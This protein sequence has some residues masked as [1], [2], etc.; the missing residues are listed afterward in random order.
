[1]KSQHQGGKG[2]QN[3]APR[4]DNKPRQDAPANQEHR[5]KPG[6]NYSADRTNTKSLGAM[7]EKERMEYY[8]KKYGFEPK[9]KAP[10]AAPQKVQ[11]KANAAEPVKEETKQEKP[12]K[13]GFFR[14]LF[15]KK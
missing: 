2:S 10:E 15:G 1:Q 4:R 9:A 6:Q 13:K 12:A 8:R 11:P 3:N 7:S 14:R 5:K